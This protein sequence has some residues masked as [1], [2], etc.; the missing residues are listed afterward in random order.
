ML[1]RTT[2]ID[3]SC[4]Q[5]ENRGGLRFFAILPNLPFLVRLR[6]HTSPAT[7][8][9]VGQTPVL[10]ETVFRYNPAPFRSA[11]WRVG[12]VHVCYA[13]VRSILRHLMRFER[14]AILLLMA[15]WLGCGTT[16]WSD[17]SRTATE[18]LLISDSIDRAVSRIDFRVLAGKKVYLDDAPVK[19]VTDYAY[20]ISTVRQH[21]LAN[22]GILKEKKEE[23]EYVLEIRAG[24]IGTNRNDVLFGI[25]A[26]TIPSVMG[27]PGGASQVPE[28]PLIK[29]TDQRGV[30]RLA[31]FVYNRQTGRPVWQS[32]AVPEESDARATWVFGAGPF[33]RG[34]IHN[35]TKFAGDK[36]TIPKI[37]MIDL[38]KD[39]EGQNGKV[40]V[41][42]E[43]YFIESKET[44]FRAIAQ[45]EEALARREPPAE[46]AGTAAPKTEP[47]KREPNPVRQEP[48]AAPIL[49]DARPNRTS[50]TFS[51]SDGVLPA[52]H[53]EPSGTNPLGQEP[54]R[55]E[56]KRVIRLPAASVS[57][58]PFGASEN[59]SF[60]KR[61][62]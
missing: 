8:K 30:A 44:D 22:G 48:V 3:V 57:D 24:A 58:E 49:H 7:T 35:G 61:Q 18:Q 16:K 37:P 31:V 4:E 5:L 42:D 59:R 52:S 2:A 26:F 62:D 51:P 56:G 45:R 28:L 40:S 11:V 17:T 29:R 50:G 20:L 13:F 10:A 25:P 1:G 33:Q 15:S 6:A 53:L 38:E 41:A 23:A 14:L 9:R 43:A 19:A 47:Q 54:E 27:M 12:A 34:T 55:V 60:P 39:R 21:V 46:N 32:G 36:F